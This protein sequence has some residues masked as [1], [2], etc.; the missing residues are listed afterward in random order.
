MVKGRGKRGGA[1]MNDVNK[2]MKSFNKLLKDPE[3]LIIFILS[4]ILFGLLL[5]YMKINKEKEEE[6]FY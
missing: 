4:L 5:Y 2:S 1:I 3:N 6:S